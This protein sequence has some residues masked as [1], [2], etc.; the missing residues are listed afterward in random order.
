[1]GVFSKVWAWLGLKAK[2]EVVREEYVSIPGNI[3]EDQRTASNIVSIHS[4]K[5]MKVV[6]CEPDNFEEVQVLADHLK[7]RKQL[8]LNFRKHTTG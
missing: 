7:S 1:M 6:V 5:T 8:I 3:E 2:K 4:N